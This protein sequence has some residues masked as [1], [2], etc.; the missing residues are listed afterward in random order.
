MKRGPEGPLFYCFYLK[1]SVKESIRELFILSILVL[2]VLMHHWVYL[3][4]LY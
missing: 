3:T 4:M 2:Q 1:F